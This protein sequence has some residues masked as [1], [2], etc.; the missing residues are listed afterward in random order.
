MNRI[1]CKIGKNTY[2][3][4]GE[5]Y[6]STGVYAEMYSIKTSDGFSLYSIYDG[7]ILFMIEIGDVD[8]YTHIRVN[9]YTK[10]SQLNRQEIMGDDNFIKFIS[11]IAYYF[12]ASSVIIYAD[13]MSCDKLTNQITK[14]ELSRTRNIYKQYGGVAT[15]PPG[16]Q[17]YISE[18]LMNNKKL[19]TGKKQRTYNMKEHTK[20]NNKIT[21]KQK[22]KKENNNM[23]D[24]EISGGSYCLDFYKYLKYNEKRYE[25]TNTL[26]VELQ[27]KFSYY[28]LDILKTITPNEVLRKEDRDEIYQIYTKNYLVDNNMDDT[29]A[30]FYIW[31]IEN[32]CYLMD[33]FVKKMDIL[34]RENNPFKQGM[35]SLD[36]MAYLYNRK[37]INTYSRYLK[38]VIDAEHQILTLPK[39]D[40]RIRR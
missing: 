15:S 3:V 10:Y 27:P 39:N 11:S 9:Y 38:I 16:M 30:N 20:E 2:Y 35:Y 17:G 25:N 8:S 34:Y 32:K 1:K 21:K 5:L 29:L 14:K 22:N 33:I 12:D 37:Y 24:D 13:Y 36:A 4:V 23:I 19:Y 18:I 40:Y 28:D 7:Y 26:N 6:D 31:M